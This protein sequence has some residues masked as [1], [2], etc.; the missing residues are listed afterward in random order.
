MSHYDH[1]R[2]HPFGSNGSINIRPSGNTLRLGSN[3]EFLK[4]G[5]SPPGIPFTCHNCSLSF[6]L[7]SDFKAHKHHEHSEPPSQQTEPQKDNY[8]PQMNTF[9]CY[10]CDVKFERFADL[11]SHTEAYHPA[12]IEFTCEDCLMRFA[13]LDELDTHIY[14]EHHFIP[15]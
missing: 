14:N 6:V 2:L 8:K 12:H 10:K 7:H 5:K 15:Q 9:I 1:L 11:S 3:V 4:D 13:H